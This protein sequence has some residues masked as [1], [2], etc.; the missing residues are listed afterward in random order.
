MEIKRLEYERNMLGLEDIN[1]LPHDEID[2]I[3]D[4]KSQNSNDD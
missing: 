1:I 3:E 2:E 4:G